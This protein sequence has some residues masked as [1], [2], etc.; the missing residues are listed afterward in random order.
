M[1]LDTHFVVEASADDVD[2]AVVDVNW[3]L[4][5]DAMILDI[6]LDIID[7]V[8]DIMEDRLPVIVEPVGSRVT[9]IF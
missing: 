9:D 3:L 6:L 7:S 1:P 2:V 5:A 8:G 4:V